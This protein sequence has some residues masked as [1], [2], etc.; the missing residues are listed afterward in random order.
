[1]HREAVPERWFVID[2]IQKNERGKVDRAA[3][4]KS[5]CGGLQ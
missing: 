1:V 5:L 3:V 4:R 2:K